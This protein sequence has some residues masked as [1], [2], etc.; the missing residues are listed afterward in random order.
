MGHTRRPP[1]PED[2]LARFGARVRA[3]RVHAGLSQE[4]L[5]RRAERHSTFISVLERG[6][7]NVTLLTILDVARALGVHPTVLF[8]ED[9]PAGVSEPTSPRVRPG[10]GPRRRRRARPR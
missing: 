5:A 2:E 6:V 7:K 1:P 8:A 4:E 3:L 10:G 9:L